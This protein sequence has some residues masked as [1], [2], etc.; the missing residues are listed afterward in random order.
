MRLRL[1]PS[2]TRSTRI[3]KPGRAAVVQRRPY[4]SFLAVV[5]TYIGLRR[6]ADERLSLAPKPWRKAE[7][8][9]S[10]IV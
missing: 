6:G 4:N 9:Q 7:V 3:E 8:D 2:G 5:N 10:V 1:L